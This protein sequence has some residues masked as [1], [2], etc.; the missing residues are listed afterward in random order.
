MQKHLAATLFLCLL[1]SPGYSQTATGTGVGVANSSSNSAANS[2]AIG[3][4]NAQG[5]KATGGKSSSSLTVNNNGH[6]LAP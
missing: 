5:G 6:R 2:V 1:V 3:G 4:G